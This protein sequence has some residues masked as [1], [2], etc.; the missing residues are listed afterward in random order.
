MDGRGIEKIIIPNNIIDIY[1]RLEALLGLRL[2]GHSD[3]LTAENIL[4]DQIYK[5]G[6]IQKTNNNIEMLLT[7]VYVIKMESQSKLLEEIAFNTRVKTED[8]MLIVMDKSIHEEHLYQ[9]LQTN[10]K[11]FEISV[12]FP[13]GI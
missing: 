4:T 9:P 10:T 7:K 1:T 8:H 11:Q 12:T 2:S 13:T 6:E 3:T 5:V